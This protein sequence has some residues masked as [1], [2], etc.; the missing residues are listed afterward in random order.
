MESQIT[1]FAHQTV[2]ERDADAALRALSRQERETLKAIW[3][4]TILDLPEAHEQHF[5]SLCLGEYRSAGF[6]LTA[7]GRCA[8]E[9]VHCRA[10]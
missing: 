1:R 10:G 4:G 7:L 9:R 3:Y 5:V 8:A 6:G 2:L